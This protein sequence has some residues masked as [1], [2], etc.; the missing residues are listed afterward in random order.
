M[1][2]ARTAAP[3]PSAPRWSNCRFV[4]SGLAATPAPPP[5]WRARIGAAAARGGV[6]AIDAIDAIDDPAVLRA[7]GIAVVPA[8]V[9]HTGGGATLA[10][11][12]AGAAPGAAPDWEALAGRIADA[13][14]PAAAPGVEGRLARLLAHDVQAPLGTGAR[15]I[16]MAIE[17]AGAGPGARPLLER[18]RLSLG[19]T[20]QRVDALV[21]WL[22]L[23]EAACTAGRVDLGAHATALL[24][25]VGGAAPPRL[26]L[27]PAMG[28]RA[29]ASLLQVAL[30]ELLDNACK[31]G[32]AAA[33]PCV[34]V[35][36]HRRAGWDVVEVSDRGAGFDP[37]YAAGLFQPFTRVHRQSEFPGQGM[38]LA[39]VRR[40][41][42]RHGGWSWADV[43]T[44]GS[45]R[46]LLALP[47]APTGAE[48][49]A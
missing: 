3:R 1:N 15:L 16:E 39:L 22:R 31:F 41:A 4:R 27:G 2:S 12:L 38:G 5:A 20:A 43:A 49:D 11:P 23:S 36:L 42:E 47:A 40:V 37:A 9:L 21:R 25:E 35:R 13:V 32:A 48:A 46:L 45:T 6:D 33:D 44:P 7:F 18:A 17:S 24:A 19:S 28:V 29:D 10:L 34:T 8:I 14:A 30:R 26:E